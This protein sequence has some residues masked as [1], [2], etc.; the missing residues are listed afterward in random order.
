MIEVN[1]V[2]KDYKMYHSNNGWLDSVKSLFS[3]THYWKK[4][5]SDLNF[6]VREGELVG[7]IGPNGAGKSTTVKMLSGVLTPTAGSILVNGITPSNDRKTNAMHIGVVFGQRS[8]LYWDLPMEDTFQLFQRMYRIPAHDFRRNT[9]FFVELLEMQS[10]YRTPV[11]QLSLGQK[12]RANLAAALLHDPKI[13]YLDEPTI[14]LD[15]IAKTKIRRFLR[16]LNE[17]KKTTVILTTHD[18]DDI[19]EVCNRLMMIDDGRI[20]YDGGLPEFRDTFSG[21]TI[22]EVDFAQGEVVQGAFDLESFNLD[23]SRIQ[24]TGQTDTTVTF[25]FHRAEIAVGEAI[26]LI[27]RKHDIRDLRLKEP[28]LEKTIGMIY[29]NNKRERVLG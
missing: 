9:A 23:D 15:V 8:Q 25:K 13:L 19:E 22:L 16:E 14:G 18:M 20:I 17:E 1:G 21:G 27:T 7:F 2:S 5:V 29:E 4:A 26:S 3:R 24:V 12:M 28:E 6:H 11:R 10:F